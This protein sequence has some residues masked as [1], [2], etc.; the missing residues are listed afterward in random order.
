AEGKVSPEEKIACHGHYR[1]GGR[2]WGCWNRGGHGSLNLAQALKHSCDVFFY[3]LGERLGPD[4]L[5][6]YAGL[7][8][9]GA[10]TG[11]LADY[12]RSGLIPTS[13]WKQKRHKN[14]WKNSDNLGNA[15]GQGYNLVT[16]LQNALMVGRFANGGKRIQ[17]KLLRKESETPDPLLDWNIN[18]KQFAF[19]KEALVQVVEGPGG[20]GKNARLS[21][22]HV[23]GKTGTAQVVGLER[24]GKVKGNSEDHAWFVAFAPAENPEIALA[25]LVEHGGGGG[26]VAA[27]IAQKVLAAYFGK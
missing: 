10:K 21:G 20:T 24:K 26:A 15:I 4:R 22:I 2:N 25:V 27:P 6:H 8:G 7:L 23:G 19:L 1:Y 13:E 3:K 12:E 18:E 17:P 9:L 11:V 14:P 5:A 16:P